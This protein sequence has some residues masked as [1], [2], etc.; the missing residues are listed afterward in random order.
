MPEGMHAYLIDTPDLAAAFVVWLCSGK[1]D[2]AKGRYLSA[3][4][5]VDELTALQERILR[6]DLLVNRLRGKA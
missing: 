4:W 5:D 6:D 3:T 1:A 2:W